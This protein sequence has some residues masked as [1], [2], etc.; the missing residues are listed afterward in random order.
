MNSGEKE[1]LVAYRLAKSKETLSEIPILIENKLWTVA[2]NRLYYACF[3]AVNALLIQN[4]IKTQTHSGT[5]HMFALHFIKTGIIDTELGRFYSKLFER[6]H[7]GDYDDFV[8]FK[9]D[10]ILSLVD[11]AQKLIARIE[12]I[13]KK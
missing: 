10:D 13:L 9:P 2:V 12:E 1:A 7:S 5:R 11:P 6:R 8:V 4:D 3:Y